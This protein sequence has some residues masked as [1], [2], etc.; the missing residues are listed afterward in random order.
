M[1]S[2]KVEVVRL[3]MSSGADVHLKDADGKTALDRAVENK[4]LQVLQLLQQE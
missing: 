2:G 4:Q 3:L 1:V